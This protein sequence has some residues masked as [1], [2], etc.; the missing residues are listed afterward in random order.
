MSRS[1]SI[2]EVRRGKE[3]PPDATKERRGGYEKRKEARLHFCCP[4]VVHW[5]PAS[6]SSVF[7]FD[8]SPDGGSQ[9]FPSWLICCLCAPSLNDACVSIWGAIVLKYAFVTFSP[10]SLPL[11][12]KYF[13]VLPKNKS[14]YLDYTVQ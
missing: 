5:P 14:V 1:R 10:G 9:S 2:S 6:L 4:C 11:H 8:R 13:T 7:S 12:T 3:T